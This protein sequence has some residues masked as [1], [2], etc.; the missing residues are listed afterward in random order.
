MVTRHE[1]W[2]GSYFNFKVRSSDKQL[3]IAITSYQFSRR[4]LLK[5]SSSQRM[6]K[7]VSSATALCRDSS[8]H[9][10]EK[11]P[12]MQRPFKEITFKLDQADCFSAMSENPTS[13]TFFPPMV[14]ASGG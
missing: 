7:P 5:S 2:H 6:P 4:F 3:H 8:C 14:I 13:S 10:V 1:I 12:L 11:T 9:G